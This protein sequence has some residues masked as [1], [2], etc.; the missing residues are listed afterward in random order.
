[1]RR[2]SH[3]DWR[4]IIANLRDTFLVGRLLYSFPHLETEWSFTVWKLSTAEFCD[5]QKTEP[6]NS[7]PI[8]QLAGI[9]KCISVGFTDDSILF[10]SQS[11]SAGWMEERLWAVFKVI[12]IYYFR[13]YFCIWF[14]QW[15]QRT[16][17]RRSC[18]LYLFVPPCDLSVVPQPV[19]LFTR[20]SKVI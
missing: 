16:G 9:G 18:D 8:V 14:L 11:R 2:S 5:V 10:K 13:W 3:C 7:F 17:S 15:L 19:R 6:P 20:L 4:G 12:I 1:M